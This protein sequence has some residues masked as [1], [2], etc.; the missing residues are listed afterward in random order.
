MLL[1][2][3][4][5]A[6]KFGRATITLRVSR[7]PTQVRFAVEDDGPGIREDHLATIFEPFTQ[8]DTS[9]TRRRDGAGLG[10]TICRRLCERMGGSISVVSAPGRGITF[11]V[12]QPLRP[13]L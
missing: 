8:L 1:N 11:A 10:L 2:L 13:A 5:N 12:E 4:S 9:T 7:G 3:L 6:V